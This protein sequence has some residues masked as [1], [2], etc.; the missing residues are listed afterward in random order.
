[1]EKK[2][3]LKIILIIIATVIMLGILIFFNVKKNTKVEIEATIKETANDY[4]V[5]VDENDKEYLLET[6]KNYKEGDK[7][8]AILKN[9]KKGNRI[10]GEIVKIDVISKEVEFSI[11]DIV[12]D[13]DSLDNN[14]ENNYNSINNNLDMVSYVS[15][16]SKD[17]DEASEFKGKVKDK[18]VSIVDFIFYDGEI[19]GTT[20][21]ELST[22]SKLKILEL[23]LKVD[24]KINDKFPDYK[25][26][27][28]SE[29]NKIYNN[30]KT[31][32]I[33]TY[34]EITTEVCDN[35]QDL[36]NTAKEGLRD[37][38]ESFS[39]TWEIIKEMAGSGVSKLKN[40]YE[41]WRDI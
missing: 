17:V 34:F 2:L 9:V 21:K 5:V 10:T 41:I 14:N 27:I 22:T 7:I 25:N 35:D 40:W 4:I 8:I 31:K 24:N 29:G 13:N 20:F 26:N 19:N 28:S 16:F 15:D 23:F 3:D 39:L 37:M 33:E 12:D 11:T 1:M 38:K 36:C 30:V 18:F 6:N 32:A